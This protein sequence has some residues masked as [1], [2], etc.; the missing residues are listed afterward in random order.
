MALFLRCATVRMRYPSTE[1]SKYSNCTVNLK[2]GNENQR[3]YFHH[4]P[5]C[6]LNSLIWL[7]TDVII[8]ARDPT[9]N[10]DQTRIFYKPGQTCLTQTKRDLVDPDNL[11]DL[12]RF[13]PWSVQHWKMTYNVPQQNLFMELRLLYLPGEF[14]TNTSNSCDDPTSYTIRLKVHMSHVKSPSV[15]TQLESNTHVSNYLSNQKHPR[16]KKGVAKN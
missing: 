5:S 4:H 8:N 7:G 3:I 16:C 13:Q 14:F 1:W 10:P 12:T 11:D 15:W 2:Y 9:Q 6:M